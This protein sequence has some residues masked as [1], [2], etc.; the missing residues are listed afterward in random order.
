MGLAGARPVFH[1][2]LAGACVKTFFRRHGDRKLDHLIL[3]PCHPLSGAKGLGNVFRRA[4]W[5]LFTVAVG[6]ALV[7]AWVTGGSFSL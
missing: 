4:D 5:V 7:A 3:S 6:L 1:G 2:V